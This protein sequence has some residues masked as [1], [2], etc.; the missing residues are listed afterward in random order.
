[1]LWDNEWGLE[2]S[3]WERW[4]ESD[5]KKWVVSAA[6]EKKQDLRAGQR[7]ETERAVESV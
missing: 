1:V 7:G 6:F 4:F 3:F 5:T 2:P